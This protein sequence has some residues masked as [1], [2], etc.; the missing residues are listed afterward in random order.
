MIG[1][2]EASKGKC[3][4]PIFSSFSHGSCHLIKIQHASFKYLSRY[5]IFNIHGV[6]NLKLYQQ[7]VGSSTVLSPLILIFPSLI[8]HTCPLKLLWRLSHKVCRLLSS[9][10]L[11]RKFTNI[12]GQMTPSFRGVNWVRPLRRVHVIGWEPNMKCSLS[13][14]LRHFSNACRRISHGALRISICFWT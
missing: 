9:H 12:W 13:S 1:D 7:C 11:L 14:W 6:L 10:V 2:S 8:I 3:L 5:E 4:C